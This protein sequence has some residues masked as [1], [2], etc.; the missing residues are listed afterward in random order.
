MTQFFRLVK[1]PSLD[2]DGSKD[3]AAA[4]CSFSLST[5]EEGSTFS[6]VYKIVATPYSDDS[7]PPYITST[8]NPN[9]PVEVLP[10]EVF[11]LISS[12]MK[13]IANIQFK[14]LVE[15]TLK[16]MIV[17]SNSTED[18][19][20]VDFLD[21]LWG[22]FDN[23]IEFD[24]EEKRRGRSLSPAGRRGPPG[25]DLRKQ[26]QSVGSKAR[27][28]DVIDSD[29]AGERRSR[30]SSVGSRARST[31]ASASS[32]STVKPAASPLVAAK[33]KDRGKEG[34]SEGRRGKIAEDT[35]SVDSQDF[36]DPVSGQIIRSVPPDVTRA[37]FANKGNYRGIWLNQHPLQVQPLVVADTRVAIQESSL[38]DAKKFEW[39]L[40]LMREFDEKRID[41]IEIFL[42]GSRS[43]SAEVQLRSGSKPASKLVGNAIRK[44]VGV[45]SVDDGK[46]AS[47]EYYKDRG[48]HPTKS[49][50]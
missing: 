47:V 48:R 30:S 15:S 32:S 38:S 11:E 39:E 17:T 7:L 43:Q 18:V 25:K 23:V 29:S 37:A 26:A 10:L 28:G 35:D 49:G 20:P 44:K 50:P 5:E 46:T 41:K 33:D 14:A 31:Q 45:V 27:L 2:E 36:N 4:S 42:I 16:G 12:Q 40:D 1:K 9:R 13:Y 24:N 6:P 22:D 19:A 21:I 3:A 8:L 34:N